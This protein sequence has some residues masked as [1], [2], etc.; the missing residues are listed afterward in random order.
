MDW[1]S[2]GGREISYACKVMST[3]K[4]PMRRG[5]P[6]RKVA[7]RLTWFPSGSACM[8]LNMGAGAS[9]SSFSLS[10][11]LSAPISERAR[12]RPLERGGASARRRGVR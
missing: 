6:S 9:P 5:A 2:G 8:V 1:I 10:I 12:K 4:C 7:K 3:V 11:S